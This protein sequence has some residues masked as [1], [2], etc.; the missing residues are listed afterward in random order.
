MPTL[1]TCDIKGIVAITGNKIVSS[2][3]KI[4]KIR[5]TIKNC[6]E[7]DWRLFS[8]G[9]NPHSK[10]L[11]L[12]IFCGSLIIIEKNKMPTIKVKIVLV[13]TIEINMKIN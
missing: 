3:S 9:E 13:I 2:T 12:S 8:Q 5:L 4:K 1:L 6:K 11:F 10:G 7:K